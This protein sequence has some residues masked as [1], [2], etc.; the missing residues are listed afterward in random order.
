MWKL[1]R[2]RTVWKPWHWLLIFSSHGLYQGRTWTKRGAEKQM[3]MEQGRLFAE[4]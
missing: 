4:R 2:K 1:E 3:L